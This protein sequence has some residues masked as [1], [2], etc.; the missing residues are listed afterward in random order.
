MRAAILVA[1][2]VVTPAL[3]SQA[4]AEPLKIKPIIDARLRYEG[5][6]QAGIANRADAVTVRV[7]AGAE[8]KSGDFTFLAEAE[9]VLALNENYNS[10]VN[11]RTAFPIV[12]DPQTIGLNRLQL[13]YRG[14]PKTVVTIGRQRI[15]LDDQ[16][17]VGSVAWRQD[18]QTF[19]AARVEWSG[20][21]NLKVDLTYAWKVRTIWGI[22]GIPARPESISGSNIFGNASLVTK[23]GTITVFGYAVDQDQTPLL[24]N[25]SLTFGGR[26]AGTHAFDK[27]TKL[28][29]LL[30]Y[31]RQTD[32]GRNP[33]RYTAQYYA[34]DVSIGIK[35]LTIGA[36]FEILGSDT[37]AALTSFQTPLAT[38]HKFNGWADKFL[39]TPPNGLSDA[40]GSIGYGWRKVGRI[41]AIALTAVYHRF[42]SDRLGLRYGDEINLQATARL[43]RYTFLLKYADYHASGFATDTQKLWAS[44]EWV[45]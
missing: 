13:Q 44:L 7:R 23:V 39:V 27:T 21:K 42:G 20:I 14:L 3:P 18:E 2:L 45:L 38:L 1:G 30:S 15:N 40:Y 32:Y 25:S 10:S 5:V 28:A 36:G 22:D 24:A 31:A 41:D 17:F 9:G 12:P 19:D 16:R 34:G 33:N 6:D 26:F 37:G 4:S 8:A 43:K 29:V 11:G 35:T